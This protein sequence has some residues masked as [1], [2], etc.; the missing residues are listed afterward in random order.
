MAE[1]FEVPDG[2]GF[3]EREQPEQR[4]RCEAGQHQE[5]RASQHRGDAPSAPGTRPGAR[6]RSGATGQR[7]GGQAEH[8][9]D[10][11]F[12]EDQGDQGVDQTPGRL[13]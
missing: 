1:T 11:E 4:P 2:S 12:A 13:I 6:R 9:H 7:T 5:G 10:D 8:R 3:E